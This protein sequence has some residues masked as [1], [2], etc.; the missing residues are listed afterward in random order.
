GTAD[1]DARALAHEVEKVVD[2][3]LAKARGRA[4]DIAAVRLDTLVFA[5]CGRGARRPR[6]AGI[7]GLRGG[8]A[9]PAR[10]PALHVRGHT[11]TPRGPG[12][13]AGAGFPGRVAAD[14]APPPQPL[15]GRRS[16]G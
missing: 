16:A 6:R 4:K 2:A 11:R 10:H 15:T 3:V 8:R 13:A 1:E 14:G 7:R 12:A 5:A 9:E